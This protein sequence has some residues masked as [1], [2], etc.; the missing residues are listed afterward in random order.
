MAQAP[1]VA[2]TCYLKVD[3]EQLELKSEAGIEAPLFDKE[4]ATIMGQSGVAGLKETDK[5]P[6]IK[7]TFIV[8]PNFPI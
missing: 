3:G 1:K 6:F 8:G 4:R 5:M 2:G 7:G